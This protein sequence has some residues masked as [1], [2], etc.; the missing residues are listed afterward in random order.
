MKN[1]VK[2]C[3]SEGKL[4]INSYFYLRDPAVVE[5]I[6][7]AGFD[8]VTI[9]L[10]SSTFDLFDVRTMILAAELAGVTPIVRIPAG[11]WPVALRVLDAGAQGIQVPHVQT[12][13]TAK[14]AVDA[15]RYKPLGNRGAMRNSRAAR[16]GSRS[17]DEHVRQ[18]NEEILLSLMIE[19]GEGLENL[20]RIAGTDGVDLIVLGLHDLAHSLGLHHD[21]PRL[22]S[23]IADVAGRMA[24]VGKARLG[25]PLGAS[26]FS[27]SEFRE[28]GIAS[29]SI[30][31]TVERVLLDTLR[32]EVESL[33]KEELALHGAGQPD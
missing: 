32:E 23:L 9:D 30:G 25:V 27:L 12:D 10:E 22:R 1:R 4:A 8:S 13:L 28:M 11:D 5:I 7:L 21:R 3:F 29:S 19:D 16:F 24:R 14:E 6:G 18:S 33:R 31:P 17:W 26:G 2:R 15:V 20:E